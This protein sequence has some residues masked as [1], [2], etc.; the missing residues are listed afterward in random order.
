MKNVLV[1]GGTG[2]I[3]SNLSARL[4][5]L[6]CNVRIL[7]RADSDLRALAEIDVEHCIGDLRD[8]ESVQRA[9]KGCDT[10]FHTAAIVTFAKKHRRLQFE[11]NVCGTTNVV[12][13]CLAK[14]VEKLIYT[15]SIAA[16]GYPKDGGLATEETPFNWP[17]TMGYRLSKRL[18]E[19]EILNGVDRG[20]S[21]VIVN[22][23]VVIG[24][25][26][27]HVHGGQL[28]KEAKR[29]LVP[30]YLNGGMNVAYAGDVVNG[31]I[32]A[33]QKGRRGERY[34]LG[35]HNMTHKEIFRRIAE[36]VGG[37]APFVRLPIPLLRF[38]AGIIEKLSN[39]VGADPWISSDLVAGAG[40]YNWFSCEK[41]KRELGYTVT[42]FDETILAAYKWYRENGF[43]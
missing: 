5:D 6:G 13:A 3:G 27:I 24:E 19:Q 43:L 14:A 10:V 8:H 21:A 16:I 32:L 1:T 17:Q 11:V 9:T 20:L 35:G 41:A 26:D 36:L 7:R 39:L 15:S 30:F 40:M 4:L 25:R 18:A 33:A 28:V 22:P 2:F 38:G 29:G 37:R 42:P 23:S 31:H 12:E 34:I